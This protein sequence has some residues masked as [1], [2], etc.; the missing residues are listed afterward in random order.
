MPL[1]LSG[2]RGSVYSFYLWLD[3]SC[4]TWLWLHL[5]SWTSFPW[6]LWQHIM[7]VA[8]WLSFSV[9]PCELLFLL[10]LPSWDFVL[11]TLLSLPCI[12]T[13]G[14]LSPHSGFS[15]HITTS[16]LRTLYLLNRYLYACWPPPTQLPKQNSSVPINLLFILY[17]LLPVVATP[18]I[19]SSKLGP[20]KASLSLLSL[21]PS[22]NP[23]TADVTSYLFPLHP[24]PS[25][26]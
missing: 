14:A 18:Y 19:W 26:A 4:Y 3:L 15:Y 16:V 7:L 1:V 9:C 12:L 23:S 11:I 10:L 25:L 2:P 6:L 21:T 20:G 24:F 8:L 13:S 5:P 22:F 17:L